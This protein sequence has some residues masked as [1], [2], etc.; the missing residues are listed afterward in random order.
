MPDFT[1]SISMDLPIP[2]VGTAPGPEW[3]TLLNSCLTIIDGHSHVAGSG[4]PI[5]PSAMS[6]NADL[7]MGVNNLI[8][9]RTIRFTPQVAALGLA[10]DLGCLYEVADDLY[11][12]DGSGNQIRLTQSGSIVGTA[13]SI[14]GLPSG[15]AS[16]SYV[17]ISSKYVWQ[18]ATN[19]AA[20]MDMGAAI[21]RNI[22]PN[23]TYALTLQPPTGLGSNYSVTLP[24]LPASQK[25][26]T[27]D[28]SG[29]MSAPWAVDGSTIE[30]SG[31]TTVQVK[32][33]GIGTTQIANQAVTQAKLAAR[34][35]GTSVA[36]GGVAISATCGTV[37][38]SS[39]TPAA[40]TNFSLTITTTGRPVRVEVISDGTV[41]HGFFGVNP[42]G[43]GTAAQVR[44]LRGGVV[45]GSYQVHGGA[46]G[47]SVYCPSSSISF[48]DFPA[49]GTYT[50]T[51]DLAIDVA[52]ATG[53]LYYSKFVVYEI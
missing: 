2:I 6:I 33:S 23:S 17:A 12:N 3:A 39:T 30:V 19:I 26:M 15:T 53:Y 13:G 1:N 11:Y 50:Y 21:M 27:L 45:Q 34:T 14:T 18:S 46:G 38:S 49:A 5:T 48:L 8:D 31:S 37:A 40:I 20:D 42:G 35:T 52:G 10:S 29:I 47:G 28:A 16:A 43:G 51:A 24:V 4:G 7:T 9:A 44:I 25:F 41:S 36:A 22:S 32:A